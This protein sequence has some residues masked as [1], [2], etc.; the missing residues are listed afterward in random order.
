MF[1]PPS[2]LI[3][4]I[5][6]LKYFLFSA[7]KLFNGVNLYA[8]PLNK[9]RQSLSLA[10]KKSSNYIKDCCTL[11]I[12]PPDILPLLSITQIKSIPA[13]IVELFFANYSISFVIM[14]TIAGNVYPSDFFNLL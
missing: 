7:V 8:P 14:L 1:V 5:A 12:F 11:L 4:A 13:S 3:V 10:L 9:I 2:A 6:F